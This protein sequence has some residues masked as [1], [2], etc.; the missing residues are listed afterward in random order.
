MSHDC[1]RNYRNNPAKPFVCA[2]CERERR[3]AHRMEIA[4]EI[5]ALVFGIA[6]LLLFSLVMRG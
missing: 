1:K 4:G 6:A 2:A 5:A 3:F